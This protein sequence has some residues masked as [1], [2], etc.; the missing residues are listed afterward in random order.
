MA[1][2]EKSYKCF[3]NR[4][5][6]NKIIGFLEKGVLGTAKGVLMGVVLWGSLFIQ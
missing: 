1:F 2:W 3:K 5:F 4:I 6:M